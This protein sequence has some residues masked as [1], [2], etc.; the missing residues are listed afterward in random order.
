MLTWFT[1]RFVVATQLTECIVANN[2]QQTTITDEPK[3]TNSVK[4]VSS[5]YNCSNNTKTDATT[6]TAIAAT[7]E[8]KKWQTKQKT[9]KK[10]QGEIMKNEGHQNYNVSVAATNTRVTNAHPSSLIVFLVLHA[11]TQWMTHDSNV[12]QYIQPND[13]R[14]DRLFE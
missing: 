9:G 7:W 11:V 14:T 6:A 1:N 12:W 4:T 5:G 10:C 13:R 3:T 2:E 8:C